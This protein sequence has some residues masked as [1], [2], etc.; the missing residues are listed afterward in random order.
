MNR[1]V[2]KDINFN[3]LLQLINGPTGEAITVDYPFN[4]IR[5]KRTMEIGSE[6]QSKRLK[7]TYTKRVVLDDFTTLP[8]GHEDI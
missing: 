7:M 4:I 8:Y 2:R 6:S 3:S 5:C 1:Q